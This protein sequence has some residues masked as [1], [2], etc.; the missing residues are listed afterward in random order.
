MK[1]VLL[2]I[3]V[4][5]A[6][7]A[8]AQ[9]SVL[10][11][12]DS[13]YIH[14]NYTKAIE[15]YKSLKKQNEV[16]NKIAKA[17]MAMSNYDEA[18]INYEN[19]LKANPKDVLT[20]FEY[21]KLLTRIKKHKEAL[22]VFYQLIDIDYKNPN[23]HYESGL[24]MQQLR[25][26]TSQ[27]RFRTAFD[28]DSTHQKAIFQIAKYHLKKQHFTTVDKFV[29]IGLST[30][31]TNKK[32]ISL[33]AQNYYWKKEYENAALWFEKLIT[34][35][36]SSQFIHEK[37]RNCYMHQYEFEK[38][39]E[40][41]EKAIEF[42]M[43]N[44][45]NLFML[46]ELFQRIEDFKNA[47]KYMLQALLLQDI[48]LDQEYVKLGFVYNRQKKYKEAIDAYKKAVDENPENEQAHFFLINSKN[49]YYKDID[50]RINLYEAF[51]KK[52]P[53]SKYNKMVEYKIKQLKE[54]QFLKEN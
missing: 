29:D 9:T 12:A 20:L 35:N 54:A 13:L 52:F 51:L 23:Y 7:K 6:F 27:S 11:L 50:T 28:L 17:Y 4:F 36:E 32:L 44:T 26:S 5:L 22:E 37:L 25:D 53:K 39:I 31:A 8:E 49:E 15:A 34:L 21:G 3:I 16:Y 10:L 33:K 19:S 18:L 42:D 30:Y 14:G 1:K 40:H 43:M 46:G 48:P 47:E 38:A 45:T 2:I 41:G 24:V